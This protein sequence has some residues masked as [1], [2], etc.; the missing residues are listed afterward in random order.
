MKVL[1]CFFYCFLFCFTLLSQE[2]RAGD[3]FI[4]YTLD[5]LVEMEDS[6]KE[7]ERLAQ[8][9]WQ[10]RIIQATKSWTTSE[11]NNF[12]NGLIESDIQTR[13]ILKVL[14]APSYLQALQAGQINFIF[15]KEDIETLSQGSAEDVFFDFVSDGDRDIED[16]MGSEWLDHLILAIESWTDNEADRFLH[17]LE[18][19]HVLTEDTLN[20]LQATGYLQHLKE[21]GTLPLLSVFLTETQGSVSETGS[22]QTAANTI[23]TGSDVFIDYARRHLREKFEREITDGSISLEGQSFKEAFENYFKLSLPDKGS[24]PWEDRISD[25][26]RYWNVVNARLLLD[27]LGEQMQIEPLT[28]IDM[29]NAISFFQTTYSSFIDRIRVYQGYLTD[30]EIKERLERSFSAFI[31]GRS[32]NIKETLLFLDNYIGK[33]NTKKILKSNLSAVAKASS[34]LDRLKQNLDYL[35]DYLGKGDREKG[36]SKLNDIIRRGSFIGIVDFKVSKRNDVY[37]NTRVKWLEDRG[38]SQDEVIKLIESNP[39][40]FSSGDL[41]Q[42]KI[43]YL[44]NYLGK[45]DR[46]KGRSKLNDIIRRGGFQGI[47][48]FKVS[49]RNDVYENTR[50]KWLEDR[51]LSQD[52]VIELIESNPQAFSRGDL[53]QEKIDYLEN[54]LGKGDREK[55]RSKLNG[56]I[57]RG[58]FFGIVDFKVSKRND[59][60]ENTRVKWLEDRGLSQDEVIKLIE[61][62][63]QAFSSGDLSQEKIDYLENYLGKGDREKGRSKL[64]GIILRRG[65]FQ[66]IVDFKV[67]KRNGVY[68]NEMITLLEAKEGMGFTQDQVIEIIENYSL[69]IFSGELTE[70]KAISFIEQLTCS[71]ALSP[72]LSTN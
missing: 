1:F 3:I 65:G 54:Y 50:V 60:Y 57:R 62:N 8:S 19:A 34:R 55:G 14:Q 4:E 72:S 27:F 32:R 47:V 25:R 11:A 28:I 59:V 33:E 46:E 70:E 71:N 37:E 31:F 64:N 48:D 22:S 43:D 24:K 39:Q 40:A 12:L 16:L 56:I 17:S 41:S 66:G 67:S 49:K 10:D 6:D 30:A 35:E 69:K 52:E 36:R 7:F 51:G 68:E 15:Q 63:P 38:L 20:L 5:Q 9:D 58:G 44:E 18:Q 29:F 42:E 23:T 45:G 2:Q 13:D 53:S 26:A 61:S 21:S